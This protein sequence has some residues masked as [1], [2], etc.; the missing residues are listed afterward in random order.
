MIVVKKAKS[1]APSV[2]RRKAS[3]PEAREDQLIALAVDL[4][5]QQLRDGTAS[6]QVI[7]HFLKL[8]S[9]KDRLEKEILSEQKKLIKAKTEALESAKHAEEL[10]T[11]AIKAMHIYSGAS[12]E[13]DENDQN[14]Y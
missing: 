7:S 12:S 9:T 2:K 4:A 5:E 3:T 11:Q 14:L 10:Y 8:G 13:E 1:N 6:A